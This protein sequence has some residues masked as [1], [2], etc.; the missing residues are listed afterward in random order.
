M[1]LDDLMVLDSDEC[2]GRNRNF[3]FLVSEV[4]RDD[5]SG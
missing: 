4:G 2:R 1:F 5:L 3:L